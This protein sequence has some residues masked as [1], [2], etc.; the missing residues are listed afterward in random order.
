MLSRKRA[1]ST[2][3]GAS[4]P[5][6]EAHPS[7]HAARPQPHARHL[8]TMPRC[9]SHRPVP[10][11]RRSGA[12]HAPVATVRGCLR[13]PRSRLSWPPR[14]WRAAA[15]L[16]HLPSRPPGTGAR[17][18]SGLAA[19]TPLVCVRRWRV[20]CPPPCSCPPGPRSEARS[21]A[22]AALTPRTPRSRT[23]RAYSLARRGPWAGFP[24]RCTT[25]PP[26]RWT[27]RLTCSVAGPPPGRPPRSFASG[28]PG[29]PRP[30]VG[31]RP[32][33]QMRQRPVSGASST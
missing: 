21:W 26:L 6:T 15:A 16:G 12:F 22:P 23:S 25:L 11:G 5:L 32:P 1:P 8:G 4:R 29:A 31:C 2:D 30:S 14:S 27:A 24:K 3:R 10:S 19:P 18:S 13:A 20:A 9:A 7:K 33:C 17:R 28:R